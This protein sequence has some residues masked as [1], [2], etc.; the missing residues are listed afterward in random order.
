MT[1]KVLLVEDSETTNFINK[2]VLNS[3]GILDIS[4]VLNGLDAYH[5]IHQ[6]CPDVILL[7][8]DM[9]VM[10]GW[11][12]L[13]EKEMKALC[14][15]AKV[16]MLTS[17]THPRDKKMAKKYASVVA[18]LEKPLTLEKLKEVNMLMN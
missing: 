16:I 4:E 17:S 11:E 1:P 8:I 3:A 2:L 7:D 6:N 18:Y 10:D 15:D 14:L 5:Y 9:P 12:F 13:K